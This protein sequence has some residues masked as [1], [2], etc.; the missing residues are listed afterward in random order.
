MTT[1]RL[2]S[3]EVYPYGGHPHTPWGDD[4]RPAE[5]AFAKS[6]RRVTESLEA[7][8]STTEL[9]A[10][11]STMRVLLQSPRFMETGPDEVVVSVLDRPIDGMYWANASVPDTFLDL[12]A[13]QRGALLVQAHVALLTHLHE[14]VRFDP[15]VLEAVVEDLWSRGSTFAWAGPWTANPSRSARARVRSDLRDDGCGI[16]CI[17]V[18]K[19]TNGSSVFS[20]AFCGGASLVAFRRLAESVRWAG[21]DGLGVQVAAPGTDTGFA[22]RAVDLSQCTDEMPF[23]DTPP[24][25]ARDVDVPL[26]VRVVSRS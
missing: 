20:P 18:R 3:I 10:G 11:G 13:E 26:G 2:H 7:L 9:F 5:D 8:L 14:T 1:R 17:E 16:S 4:L 25:D 15:A 23:S 24:L 12:T 22:A 6:A 21:R 19:A